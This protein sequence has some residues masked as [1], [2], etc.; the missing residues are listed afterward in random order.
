MSRPAAAGSLSR[1]GIRLAPTSLSESDLPLSDTTTALSAGA[2]GTFDEEG[3]YTPRPVTS[4][5]LGMSFADAIAG[6]NHEELVCAGLRGLAALGL[7]DTERPRVLEL[8]RTA[9]ETSVRTEAIQA[10]AGLRSP[11][12]EAALVEILRREREDEPRAAAVRAL[13]FIGGPEAIKALKASL[14]S[15]PNRSAECTIYSRL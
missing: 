1:P 7:S 8:A 15:K 14:G 3:N 11:E 4:N 5:D 13:G 6:R 10:L 9:E 12:I 2:M